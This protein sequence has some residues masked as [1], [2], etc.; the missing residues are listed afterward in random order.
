MVHTL[1]VNFKHGYLPENL[2]QFE[3]ISQ[4]FTLPC[5]VNYRK[6]YGVIIKLRRGM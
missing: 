2:Y 3:I 6:I 5:N 1:C 4:Q